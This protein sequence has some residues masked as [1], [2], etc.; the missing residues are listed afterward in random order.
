MHGILDVMLDTEQVQNVRLEWNIETAVKVADAFAQRAGLQDVALSLVRFSQNALFRLPNLQLTVRIYSPLEDP[1]RV[2]LMVDCAKSL[3]SQGFPAVRVWHQIDEQPVNILGYEVSVW[4]WI[5]QAKRNVDPFYA[6]GQ[7]IRRFHD[8]DG[9]F[10]AV[11]P[12]FDP[13]I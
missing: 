2:K 8:L 12:S 4:K 3:E 7:L 5:E 6:F 13:L 9:K 1:S 10:D 11:I